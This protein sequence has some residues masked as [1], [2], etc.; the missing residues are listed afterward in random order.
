MEELITKSCGQIGLP[1][2]CD[3]LVNTPG[4]WSEGVEVELRI[5]QTLSKDA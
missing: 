1:N 4:L 2:V 3:L 5:G